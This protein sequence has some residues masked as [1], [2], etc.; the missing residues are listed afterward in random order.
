MASCFTC[1]KAIAF[2]LFLY[3]AR[4]T[5]T[6]LSSFQNFSVCPYTG[7]AIAKP[8]YILAL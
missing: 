7:K 4:H 8:N 3:N 2:Y 1:I 5:K 6:N